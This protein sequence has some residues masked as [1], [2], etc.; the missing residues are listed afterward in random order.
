[1]I[2]DTLER[3][4]SYSLI[5]PAFKEAFAFLKQPGLADLPLGRYEIQGDRLFCTI[6][7][8]TGRRRTEAKLEAHRKYIDIQYVIDGTEEMGWRQT[9]TCG[10]VRTNYD[11]GKDI[12]FFEDEPE[13]WTKVLPGSFV[14]FLPEDAH[15]PLVGE[16]GIHKVV[17]KVLLNP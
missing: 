4:D 13:T 11:A 16:G 14:I 15:A 1:M 2:I 9:S 6:S 12:G 10:R 3:A 7:K 8:E 5:H 17:I